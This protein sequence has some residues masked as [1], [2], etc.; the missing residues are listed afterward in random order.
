M[1]PK[2]ES[3]LIDRLRV[4]AKGA[5]D[6]LENGRLGAADEE[7]PDI[8][9]ECNLGW[10]WGWLRPEAS[11]GDRNDD[12]FKKEVTRDGTTWPKK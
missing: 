6:Q 5:G 10:G 1:N 8:V 9:M 4:S 3:M 12:L 11:K 7:E 2:P